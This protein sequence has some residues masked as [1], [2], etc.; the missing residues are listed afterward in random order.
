MVI[1]YMAHTVQFPGRKIRWGLLIKGQ[2]GDGKTTLARVLSMVMGGN[3]VRVVS[4]ESLNSAFN[5]WAFGA[6]LLAIEEVRAIGHS[7]HD[8]LNKLKPIVTNDIIEIVRKGKDGFEVPN[9]ANII[10]M[11]NHED[12]LPVDNGDRRWGVAF[13]KYKSRQQ[14]MD[15]LP[16]EYFDALYEAIE[17]DIGS[18]RGWLLSINLDGFFRHAAPEMTASKGVMSELSQSDEHTGIVEALGFTNYKGI[19]ESFVDIQVLRAVL[20]EMG[21]KM[22]DVRLTKTLKTMG[23]VRFQRNM[24]I[25]GHVKTIY[26]VEG[27]VAGSTNEEARRMLLSGDDVVDGSTG[28][29]FF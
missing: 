1:N 6:C 2:Q 21:F 4:N 3:T 19:S 17:S 7:R 29:S 14:V 5:G 28:Y 24:K 10:A 15:E 20:L 25:G 13:T 23:W 11:T 22:T 16:R 12:A 26:A 8:V 18:I 9:T 27:K